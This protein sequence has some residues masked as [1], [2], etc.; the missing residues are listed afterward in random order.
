MNFSRIAQRKS[1][2]F[3]ESA[4][5]ASTRNCMLFSLASLTCKFQKRLSHSGLLSIICFNALRPSSTGK[6]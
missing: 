1:Q 3:D 6:E 4:D 5:V 2:D